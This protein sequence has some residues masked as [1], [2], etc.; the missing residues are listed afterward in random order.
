MIMA[1]QKGTSPTYN[2]L[3]QV[4]EQLGS[5]RQRQ[6]TRLMAYLAFN[7]LMAQ[8]DGSQ[9]EEKDVKPIGPAQNPS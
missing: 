6:V 4:W 8:F 9:K 1:E 7:L 3:P 2:S 5:E